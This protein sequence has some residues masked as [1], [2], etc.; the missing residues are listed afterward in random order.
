VGGSRQRVIV[1]GVLVIA[2]LL[3][4]RVGAAPA[5][6]QPVRADAA[7][8]SP[9]DE[10]AHAR[11][12]PAHGEGAD[13]AS[14]L[15]LEG[16]PNGASMSAHGE[17]ADTASMLPLGG[18]PNGASMSAHGRSAPRDVSLPGPARGAGRPDA[19]RRNAACVGCHADVAAEWRGSLHRRAYTDT[20]FAE[21]LAREPAAFCRGCHA[22]E[23]DPAAAAPAALARLGVGCITCHVPGDVVLAAP[24]ADLSSETAP[25]PV[26]RDPRFAGDGACAGCHE[27]TFPGRRELMQST[28]TEHRASAYATTSCADCHMPRIAGRRSHGFAASRDPELLRKALRVEVSRTGPG[29]LALVLTPG[30]VGHAFP[31]GDLFRR[32]VVR[33]ETVDDG[34]YLADERVLARHFSDG[35]RSVLR[36]DRPGAPA[37]AGAAV[38]VALELGP[39]ATGRQI[40]WQVVHERIAFPGADPAFPSVLA[41]VVVAE[42]TSHPSKEPP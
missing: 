42:G 6:G 39:R 14:M 32:L 23:A 35:E 37:L 18:S 20:A 25:H 5:D 16:S 26:R 7:A 9:P 19:A 31:T 17:A 38:D 22:P 10:R 24:R 2:G 40:R 21:A 34:P 28:V 8:M 13:T 29:A 1:A 12:M 41:A 36:D 30:A 4:L 15:P 3:G 11:S 27:F 33:A